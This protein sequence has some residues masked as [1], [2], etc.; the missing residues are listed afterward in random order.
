[1]RVRPAAKTD[2]AALA[3]LSIEVWVGTYLRRGV[4]SFFGAFVLSEFT[5]G[6]FEA[7]IDAGH[8][9]LVV[10]EN[11]D[12]I[13]GFIRMADG[14]DA[15][16]D[17]LSDLEIVTFYVQPSHHG[18]GIG[19]ALLDVA[20]DYCR[21]KGRNSIWLTTNSENKPAIDF[22]IAKGFQQVGTTD[23]SIADQCYPNHVL[24]L[25]VTARV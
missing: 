22:Y 17:G 4:N 11:Q 5:Q 21:S 1:M 12:G 6:K 7:T 16:V 23:F 15:P 8:D 25:D 14:R 2:A 3:A 13:D 24:S 18:N 10:S 19:S 20:T 9:L